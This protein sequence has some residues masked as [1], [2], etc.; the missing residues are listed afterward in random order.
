MISQVTIHNFK[1]LRDVTAD[2]ERFTIFV[3]PNASGKSSILQALDILCR[4][5]R[6]REANV[7]VELLQA[8][9]QR[10]NGPVELITKTGDKWYRYR[11]ESRETPSQDANQTTK[12]TGG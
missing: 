6:Q 7:E 11:T 2:L 5:F 3:G 9:S 10:S 12:W 8:K 4:V 1:S